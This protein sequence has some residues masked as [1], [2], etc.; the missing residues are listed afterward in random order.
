MGPAVGRD[1]ADLLP[2]WLETLLAPVVPGLALKAVMVWDTPSAKMNC[3][4]SSIFVRPLATLRQ[5]EI[6]QK[7]KNNIQKFYT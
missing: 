6:K 2:L 3:S 1:C 7:H 5:E 4:R